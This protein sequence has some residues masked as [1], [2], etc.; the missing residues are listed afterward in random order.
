MTPNAK[1]G[2]TAGPI[3][4]I[5]HALSAQQYLKLHLYCLFLTLL[6]LQVKYQRGKKINQQRCYYLGLSLKEWEWC[7]SNCKSRTSQHSDTKLTAHIPRGVCVA[8]WKSVCH[9]QD[10]HQAMPLCVPLTLEHRNEAVSLGARPVAVSFC[11]C[12]NP[13]SGLLSSA[14]CSIGNLCGCP[15]P[16]T[17]AACIVVF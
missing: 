9:T 2:E 8:V 17:N 15:H 4:S 3:S 6:T 7:G 10:I 11:K 13:T 1:L 14:Y 5:S 16:G 12:D